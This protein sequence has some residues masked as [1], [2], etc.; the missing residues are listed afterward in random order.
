MK[1][2]LSAAGGQLFAAAFKALKVLRPVRPIHPAGVAFTGVIERR[3]GSTVSGISWVDTAGRDVVSARLSRSVGTPRNWPDILGLALRIGTATGPADLLLAST[4][5]GWP[6]RLL[7]TA[8]RNAGKAKLTS[9]M[10]YKG[11][12]GPV[13]LAAFPEAAGQVLP[14]APAAFR[15]A[16]GAG[17]WCLGLYHARPRGHWN[18]FGTLELT[19]D[20]AQLD[21]PTR[22]DPLAN[23]VPGAGT[24]AWAANLRRLSYQVARR[25][26]ARHPG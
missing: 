16:L 6:G 7:L 8:H 5:A 13:L 24:Y 10:P 26:A 18:R 3:P 14:A 12:K 20:S 1:A 22:F 15:K 21:L 4:A 2:S 19:L 17:T 25:P 9:L 23:T 11:S